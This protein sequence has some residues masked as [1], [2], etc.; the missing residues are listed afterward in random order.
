MELMGLVSVDS[1]VALAKETS[2]TGR[3]LYNT[4]QK[5][6]KKAE[7]R[8][9]RKSSRT[10]IGDGGCKNSITYFGIEIDIVLNV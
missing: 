5:S 2:T 8:L 4:E 6:Y 9:N 1:K 10:S 7:K 3:D